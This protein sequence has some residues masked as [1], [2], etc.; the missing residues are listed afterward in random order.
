MTTWDLF[1]RTAARMTLAFVGVGFL[2]TLHAAAAAC[3]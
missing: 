2:Y 1:E 3:L